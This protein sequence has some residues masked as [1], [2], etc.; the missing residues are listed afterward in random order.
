LTQAQPTD[1]TKRRKPGISVCDDYSGNAEALI[2]L[3][4]RDE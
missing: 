4:M 1:Q 3:G 2:N